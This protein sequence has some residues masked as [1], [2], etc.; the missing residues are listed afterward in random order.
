MA[1]N[2]SELNYLANIVSG[3]RWVEGNEISAPF[4]A[5]YTTVLLR[6]SFGKPAGFCSEPTAVMRQTKICLWEST[7]Q[8]VAE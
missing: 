1:I 6:R 7:T 4:F 2:Y 5:G 3:A 8:N